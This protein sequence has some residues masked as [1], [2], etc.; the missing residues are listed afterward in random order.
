MMSSRILRHLPP[1]SLCRGSSPLLLLVLMLMGAVAGAA[2]LS[3]DDFRFDGPLGSHGATI[4]RLGPNHFKMVLGHAVGNPTWA[5]APQF[6]ISGNAKGNR[7]ILD[8]YFFGGKAYRFNAHHYS[9]SYDGK[10]WQPISWKNNTADSSQGDRLE[11]PEFTQDVVHV[12]RQVPM[13]YEDLV[14]R[15]E[16]WAKH[17]HA[18][19]QVVGQSL[20][21]RNLYRLEITDPR[22]PHPPKS[23]WVH[24]FAN[25]HPGEFNSIWR[26]VGM[27]EWLLGDAG[28]DCRRRSIAHF[29]LLSSPDGPS[30]GW[31]RIGQQGVDMNRCYAADGA[32][33][34]K[35]P[36]E[37]YLLQRDFEALMASES[38]VTAAWSMH[39]WAGLVEPLLLP[40]PEIGTALGP[41]TDF[42]EILKRHDTEGLIKPLALRKPTKDTTRWAV[43]PHHQ[44]GITCVL[45]EGAGLFQHKQENLDSG[46]ALMQAIADYYRGTKPAAP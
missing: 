24:Y 37:G 14:E 8:V 41:W 27:I 5:N 26:M 29:V 35:Q 43:G 38:P 40:G 13:A 32:D 22:S 12:G 39:T 16:G 45:C 2:E 7:L 1:W 30:H 19:V 11:F 23:R 10:Q 4:E 20:G 31:Y 25:Q 9:W 44:F 15:L 28:A 46:R 42:R 36:H 34:E 6:T 17:P 18:K 3:V 33:A 21:K